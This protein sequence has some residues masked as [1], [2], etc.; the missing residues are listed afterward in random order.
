MLF[1]S[2]GD[3]LPFV[4]LMNNVG[5]GVNKIK[6]FNN[7]ETVII[8]WGS[9]FLDYDNDTDLDLFNSNGPI[10]P[11]TNRI[12]NI[13]FENKGR[14]FDVCRDSGLMDFGIGRGSVHFDYDNDGDQD[15]L[16]VVKEI[17]S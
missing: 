14:F 10:N 1:R 5:T 13:L 2:R 11:M 4:N 17:I 6:S 8:G 12:P 15:I 3:G 7:R 9:L 16:L